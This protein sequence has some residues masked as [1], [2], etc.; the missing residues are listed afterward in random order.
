MGNAKPAPFVPTLI[1]L[2]AE[3]REKL[4]TEIFAINAVRESIVKTACLGHER[5]FIRPQIPLDFR[6]TEAAKALCAHLAEVRATAFWHP[7]SVEKDGRQ[8]TGFE[9]EISW[10]KVS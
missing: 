2:A 4:A 3:A 10:R 8:E 7:Y 5:L 6:G 9:L 1:T